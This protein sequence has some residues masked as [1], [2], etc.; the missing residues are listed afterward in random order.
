MKKEIF[1]FCMLLVVAAG[2]ALHAQAD[3]EAA[4]K[5]WQA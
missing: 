4:M 5:A 1:A 3:Q 2:T